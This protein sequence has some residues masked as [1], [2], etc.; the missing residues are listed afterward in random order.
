MKSWLQED[1][2]EMYS[3]HNEEKFV[4]AEKFIKTLTNEIY[5]TSVSKNLEKD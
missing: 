4:A 5:V 1:D 3:L 2:I